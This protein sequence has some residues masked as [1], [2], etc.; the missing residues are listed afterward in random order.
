M[1]EGVLTV[2]TNYFVLM[3]LVVESPQISVQNEFRGMLYHFGR[4]RP[5]TAT[6]NSWTSS[7]RL[8][9]SSTATRV[10]RCQKTT[11]RSETQ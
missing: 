4:T 2:N 1:R 6:R 11:E 9:Q 8:P 3:K 7:S 5:V 10:Q